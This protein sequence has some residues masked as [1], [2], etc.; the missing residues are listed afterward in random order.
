MNKRPVIS[1]VYAIVL[2]GSF[3][4]FP[5]GV[6][7]DLFIARFVFI[8]EPQTIKQGE[9]SGAL[10]VQ[11]QDSG[12]VSRKSD[13]TIDLLFSSTS[14]TGEFLNAAG[15]SVDL[16]MNK[17]TANRTFYYRNTAHSTDTMTAKATGR[18]SGK[19]WTASQSISI[20][21]SA[22]SPSPVSSSTAAIQTQI[23]TASS[24]QGKV[25]PLPP[26]PT[27]QAFAGEDRV[28]LVGIEENFIGEAKGLIREPITNARFWWN[29]GDGETREGRSVGHTYR[30]PGA[31]VIALSVSSGEYAASDYIAVRVIPNKIAIAQVISGE[32]GAIRLVNPASVGADIGGWILED[33]KNKRF[34]FPVHTVIGAES[35]AAFANRV[36]GLS[37]ESKVTL[38]YPGGS[39]AAWG[40]IGIVSRGDEKTPADSRV[41]K[42]SLSSVALAVTGA[43]SSPRTQNTRETTANKETAATTSLTIGAFPVMSDGEEASTTARKRSIYFPSVFFAAALVLSIVAA[44]G[45]FLARRILP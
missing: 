24:L 32:G 31:Y 28:V 45:F 35:E 2:A 15:G 25:S 20:G 11:S 6:G 40:D 7:A 17:N 5:F 34:F 36:T 4:F 19:S 14:L 12:G 9:I 43:L 30:E 23:S 39:P 16:V 22:V 44:A 1:I 21:T 13:E 33:D 26:M 18:V 41:I 3:L 37:P 38:R 10:T 8:T 42:S 29:F 27:I